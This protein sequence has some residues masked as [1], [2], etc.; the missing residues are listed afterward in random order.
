MVG[1]RLSKTADQDRHGKLRYIYIYIYIFNLL[2][3]AV[4]SYPTPGDI[5]DSISPTPPTS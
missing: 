4:E 5:D 3:C 2:T 1:R